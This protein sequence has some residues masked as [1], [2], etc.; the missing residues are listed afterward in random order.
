[1]HCR[2]RYPVLQLAPDLYWHENI[3]Q[4]LDAIGHSN[5]GVH[6][7]GGGGGGGGGQS[8]IIGCS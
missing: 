8:K 6:R 1:M 2:Y 4:Y 7:G 5:Q 3:N